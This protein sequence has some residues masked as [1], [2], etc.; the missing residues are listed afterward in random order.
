MFQH[1][2]KSWNF[3]S[4]FHSLPFFCPFSFCPVYLYSSPLYTKGLLQWLRTWVHKQE[5]L[6]QQSV[7][8]ERASSVH[9]GHTD[10]KFKPPAP[11][12][13][14]TCF[15]WAGR[16]RGSFSL[17]LHRT[18]PNF[19]TRKIHSFH[20]IPSRLKVHCKRPERRYNFLK[21]HLQTHINYSK[22]NRGKRWALSTL[23][24]EPKQ[25]IGKV[26]TAGSA[27]KSH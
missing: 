5:N 6:S 20:S 2:A 18:T 4:S 22:L 11:E 21:S 10:K 12:D 16:C 14:V 17:N 23:R 13:D 26:F 25:Q 27:T 3:H 1:N 15:L 19:L 7:R 8:S 24:T 9:H